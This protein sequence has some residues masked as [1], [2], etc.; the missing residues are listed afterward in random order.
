MKQ[1]IIFHIQK[2]SIHDGPGIRTTVFLKGCPL[3]CQWCHN[4]EG[5]SNEPELVTIGSRCIGC[6]MCILVCP[7]GA[8]ALSAPAVDSENQEVTRTP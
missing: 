2:Y 7:N 4:P 6:G 1:G 5:I 3:R 8:V